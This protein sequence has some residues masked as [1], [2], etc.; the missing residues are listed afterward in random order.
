[1]LRIS[2][3]FSPNAPS[4]LFLPCG[5]PKDCAGAKVHSTTARC[6]AACCHA[7]GILNLI[8]TDLLSQSRLDQRSEGHHRS[9]YVYEY[10]EVLP[11]VALSHCFGVVAT[12]RSSRL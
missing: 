3:S 6:H 4:P 10:Y 11:L 9:P 12:S 2:L 8:Q 1:V 5:S 7:A